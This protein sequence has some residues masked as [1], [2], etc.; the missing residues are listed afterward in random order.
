MEDLIAAAADRLLAAWD[1]GV[2]C[3]PVR[4]LFQEQDAATAYAIQDVNTRRWEQAGRRIVGRKVGLTSRAVQQQ[5]GVDTPDYGQLWADT[6]YSDSEPVPLRRVLQPRAEGEVAL[7]LG[8]DLN[9]QHI[10]L[11]DVL[12]AVEYALPAIEIAGSRVA[13]WDIR[14]LD[15]IADNASSGAFVLGTVPRKLDAFDPRLCGMVLERK[16]EPVSVGAGAACLGNPLTSALW[17]AR[18]MVE[19]GRP[20]KEG[21]IVLTGALGPLV[22]VSPGDVLELRINGLGHTRAVFA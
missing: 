14:L 8:R 5:L 22:P 10:V 6:C 3:P 17:L 20:L 2:P 12:H 7:V 15:T 21:D 11:T 18:K 4:D 13:G 19:V 9:R 16:G 1:S